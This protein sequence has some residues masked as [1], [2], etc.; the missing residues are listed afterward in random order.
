[1]KK[2]FLLISAAPLA[3]ASPAMAEGPTEVAAAATSAAAQAKPEVFSTGVA[4]GRD[5]LDSATSTSALRGEEI[6][7]IGTRNVAEVLRN[8]PGIRVEAAGGDVNNNITIRGLPL[9]ATG[10]KYLQL[11]EDGLPVLEYGDLF[12]GAD[13]FLRP[14]FNL[15]AVEAIRGGSAP[16]PGCA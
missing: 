16:I 5:R 4:K 6:Q 3:L 9:A 7:K 1:M 12:I 10:S 14:D 15:N 11:Q 2:V 13:M 8:I